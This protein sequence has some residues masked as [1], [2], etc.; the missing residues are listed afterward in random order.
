M[1]KIDLDF[2]GISVGDI[3]VNLKHLYYFTVVAEVG[4]ITKAAKELYVTQSMLSK[5][6]ILLEKQLGVSL[7]KRNH[8]NLEV[9][10]E[11]RFLYDKWKTQI[12]AFRNDI[13]KA[14]ELGHIGVD[15]IRIGCFPALDVLD[16]MKKYTD[17]VS[18]KKPGIFI[19]ILRM[20]NNRLFEHLISEQ[21]DLILAFVQ[22]IPTG[23]D[24]YEWKNIIRL[25]LVA[26]VR[27]EDPLAEKEQLSFEDLAGKNIL[28]NDPGGCIPRKE[29]FFKRCEENHM[30]PGAVTMVNND[31]T[32]ELNVLNGH[33]VAVG[34]SCVYG[35]IGNSVKEIPIENEGIDVAGVWLKKTPQDLKEFYH[36][37][38]E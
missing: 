11:G 34:I 8:H 12:K 33:G 19:E 22:D 28:L 21:A 29:W 27:E 23:S 6:L 3:D 26:L 31:L 15:K 7:F 14:R 2:N 13:Q 38:L 20:N 36:A 1:R 9:T 24:S 37:I 30:I 16:F 18:E 35:K 32:A 25:P 5:N 17:R 10:R 4:N